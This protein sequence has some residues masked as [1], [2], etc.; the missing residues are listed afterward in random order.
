MNNNV[1]DTPIENNEIKDKPK[2]LTLDSEWIYSLSSYLLP[3]NACGQDINI[4][5]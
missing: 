4:L 1:Q 5:K 2:S 3:E